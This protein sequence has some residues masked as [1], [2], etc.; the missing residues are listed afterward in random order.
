MLSRPENRGGTWTDAKVEELKGLLAQN[1]SAS[2][3][4][5][6]MGTTRNSV[7]GKVQRLGMAHEFESVWTEDRVA[8]LIKLWCEGLSYRQIGPKLGLSRNTVMG[9]GTRLR[10]SETHPRGRAGRTPKRS[11]RT[12][13]AA[14][15]DRSTKQS[16]AKILKVRSPSNGGVRV[17]P[18]VVREPAPV[19]RPDFLS[20]ALLDIGPRMCRYPKGGDD[21]GTPILFCGQ[22]TPENSSWCPSCARI[23]YRIP[24][25][26]TDRPYLPTGGTKPAV[27]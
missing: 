9:K 2:E 17:E 12:K 26:R 6:V 14:D 1:K 25:P 20:I 16:I 11:S 21:D 5:D 24:P 13:P 19:V 18:M 22:S 10:L 23:V 27:F 3:I 7:L 8:Q 4:A 15:K